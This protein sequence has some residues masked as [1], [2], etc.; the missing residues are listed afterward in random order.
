MSDLT[1]T[2][3]TYLAAWTEPDAHRRLAMVEQ[4]WTPDGRLIDPPL[5]AEGHTGISDLFAAL[6]GQFPGHTFRRASGV[7][8]HH[9]QF[10]FAWQLVGP[11]GTVALTG[12]DVGETADDGRLRRITGFFGDVPEGT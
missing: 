10:R 12:L 11:D 8:A 1:T 3:D 9:D 2:I 5:A 7:D 4:V 6:Q